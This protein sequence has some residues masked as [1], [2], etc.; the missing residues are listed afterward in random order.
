HWDATCLFAAEAVKLPKCG[1]ASTFST[2][3]TGSR[4][5]GNEPWRLVGGGAGE[6]LREGGGRGGLAPGV[7]RGGELKL[8]VV[9]A[10]DHGPACARELGDARVVADLIV[11]ARLEGGDVTRLMHPR[12][13]RVIGDPRPDVAAVRVPDERPGEV[14]TPVG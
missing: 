10:V 1:V 5:A 8:G 4:Q 6:R 12:P 9:G 14:A 13:P 11:G 3:S 7:R 2:F